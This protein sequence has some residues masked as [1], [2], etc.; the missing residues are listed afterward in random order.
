[1]IVDS[2]ALI[3]LIQR[4]DTAVQVAEVLSTESRCRIGA[5][6]WTETLIVLTHRYGPVGRT[7]VERVRQEFALT[8]IDYTAD[9]AAI[10]LDAFAR[11]GKGRH[12]AALN[13]GDCMAY[14]AARYASESLLA[15]GDDFAHTDLVFDSRGVVGLWAEHG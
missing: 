4:G 14:A 1:M 7:I 12:K 9:H 2:S 3:A 15:A 5:S 11:F 13:F 8:V 10:A 6:T